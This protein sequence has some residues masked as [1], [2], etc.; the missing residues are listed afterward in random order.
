MVIPTTHGSDF[1]KTISSAN[2]SHISNSMVER[3]VLEA[4]VA[5]RVVCLRNQL[6][7]S[8]QVIS[9]CDQ[10]STSIKSQTLA[11]RFLY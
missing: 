4:D 7:V 5:D 3:Q 2:Q 8:H 10:P 6:T 1:I 11:K 9:E